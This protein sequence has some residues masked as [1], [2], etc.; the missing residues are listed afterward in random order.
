MDI[1]FPFAHL[2][3]SLEILGEA[4]IELNIERKTAEGEGKTSRRRTGYSVGSA[5]SRLSA[6]C[7]DHT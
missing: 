5:A 3:K 1:S 7:P 6:G 4:E 2:F